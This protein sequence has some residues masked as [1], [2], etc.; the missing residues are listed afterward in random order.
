MKN[1]VQEVSAKCEQLPERYFRKH[2]EEYGGNLTN[3]HD[4]TAEIPVIDFSLLAT[5]SPSELDKLKSAV[6]TWGCFQ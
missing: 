2:D 3:A 5:S 4:V 1:H 6:I